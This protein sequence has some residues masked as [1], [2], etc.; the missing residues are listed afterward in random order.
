MR[1]RTYIG[2]YKGL[3]ID[4][5]DKRG[6]RA[7]LYGTRSSGDGPRCVYTARPRRSHAQWIPVKYAALRRRFE[8]YYNT[9]DPREQQGLLSAMVNG[10]GG[11]LL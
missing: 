5:G 8:S 11:V 4:R 2:Y 7:Y 9:C 1:K 10:R 6:G 3:R